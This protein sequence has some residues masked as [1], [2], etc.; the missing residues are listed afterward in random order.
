MPDVLY[1]VMCGKTHVQLEE[2]VDEDQAVAMALTHDQAHHC[3][4]WV[5]YP[6]EHVHQDP[7]A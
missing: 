1:V 6:L 5:Q 7:D 2:L 3:S 4:P